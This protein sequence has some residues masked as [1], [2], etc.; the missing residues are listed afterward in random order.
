MFRWRIAQLT[1]PSRRLQRQILEA[2]AE[3]DSGV[4]EMLVILPLESRLVTGR[5]GARSQ[6]SPEAEEVL[7]LLLTG[8]VRDTL[9]VDCGRHVDESMCYR[10][11]RL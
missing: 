7:D 2:S 11:Y 1:F 10:C 3:S 4:T 9:D 5:S 6:D 8:L